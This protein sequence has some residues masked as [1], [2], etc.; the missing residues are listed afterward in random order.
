MRIALATDAWLPQVNG[1]VRSL[2]TTVE[3][4]RRR[5]HE[6]E[7][8]TPDRFRT[9]PCPSYPEIR[10]ALVLP[11]RRARGC[12][13]RFEPDAVHI[14]TEGPIGWAARSWCRRA[15]LP[16]TTSSTRAFPIM[17]RCAPAF[18]RTGSGR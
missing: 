7:T 14:A 3:R 4:L 6:V 13:T 1:V 15:R 17:C 12:S 16:F 10:L 5:G 9:V 11:A 18:R 8:I 2:S